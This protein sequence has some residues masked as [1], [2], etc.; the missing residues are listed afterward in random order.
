MTTPLDAFVEL[1]RLNMAPI[2]E[3]EGGRFD[4]AFKQASV[5]RSK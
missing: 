5:F 1:D 3:A 4:P 2:I